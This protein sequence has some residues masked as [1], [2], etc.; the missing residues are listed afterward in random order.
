MSAV[1][2]EQVRPLQTPAGWERLPGNGWGAV[3]GAAAGVARLRRHPSD[4][5]EHQ[6]QVTMQVGRRVRRWTE[7]RSVSDQNDIDEA[8]NEYLAAA[9]LPARPAGF[10]WFIR[11]PTGFSGAVTFHD[12]VSARINETA[13]VS[14]TEVLAETRRAIKAIDDLGR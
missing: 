13:A 3:I 11:K 4:R 12:T 10:D 1:D 7:P 9:G 6:T 5:A 14:P 2:W 8:A